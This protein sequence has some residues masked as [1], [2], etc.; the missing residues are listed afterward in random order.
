MSM[1][2]RDRR[3]VWHPFRLPRLAL[4]SKSWPRRESVSPWRTD[5][6]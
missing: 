6:N 4:S 2:E 3:R 1:L 5:A